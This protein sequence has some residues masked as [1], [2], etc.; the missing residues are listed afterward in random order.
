[1]TFIANFCSAIF[2]LNDAITKRKSQNDLQTSSDAKFL[3]LQGK[4]NERL[5][6]SVVTAII[7]LIMGKKVLMRAGN[8]SKFSN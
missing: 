7:R 3:L 5:P 4:R 6:K 8:H 2:K 1:M